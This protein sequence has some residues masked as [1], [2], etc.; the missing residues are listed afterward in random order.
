LL[1]TLEDES[2]GSALQA[3]GVGTIRRLGK[4][5]T[6]QSGPNRD[7]WTV[8]RPDRL[9]APLGINDS[10]AASASV[11]PCSGEACG[12]LEL[13]RSPCGAAARRRANAVRGVREAA[14]WHC[15]L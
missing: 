7:E 3:V 2:N 12:S 1:R 10:S 5:P 11:R 8:D 15:G 6:H 13:N 9:R 4:R 14:P